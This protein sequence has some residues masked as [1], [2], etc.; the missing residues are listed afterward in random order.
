M[1][2]SI[3]Y[4]DHNKYNIQGILRQSSSDYTEDQAISIEED[5]DDFEDI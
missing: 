4:H 3:F 5:K 2:S 1:D